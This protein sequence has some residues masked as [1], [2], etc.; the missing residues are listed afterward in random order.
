MEFETENIT[1]ISEIGRGSFGKVF[2]SSMNDKNVLVKIVSRNDAEKAISDMIKCGHKNLL[3]LLGYAY[4]RDQIWLVYEYI[5]NAETL[6]K[7]CVEKYDFG[8]S[9]TN[10]MIEIT[11]AVKHLHSLGVYHMDIKPQNIIIKSNIPFLIDYGLAIRHDQT[12][13]F[14]QG[15][16]LYMSPE[17]WA[18]DKR[19][20]L[21]KPIYGKVN[22]KTDV[23]S[24]GAVFHR[25]FYGK[26][27]YYIRSREEI[28]S[29]GLKV[30][31]IDSKP[32]QE[33]DSTLETLISRML[34]KKSAQ[35]PT[36]EEVESELLRILKR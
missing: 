8:W 21:F 19:Y 36:L 17:V 2:L 12:L 9:I 22:E 14:V 34:R 32:P 35:R 15:T 6:E 10:I 16:P 1:L 25:M 20:Y 27:P 3:C 24:L 26:P 28:D 30:L 29:F 18:L 31:M 4:D 11:Q 13:D 7:L 5:E 33:L 23:Y